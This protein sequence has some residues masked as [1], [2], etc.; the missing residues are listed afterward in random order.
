MSKEIR[1]TNEEKRL[2]RFLSQ[3]SLS[4]NRKLKAF[5]AA[6]SMATLEFSWI[7]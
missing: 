3:V 5:L 1:R 2:L 6:I 4:G 7:I